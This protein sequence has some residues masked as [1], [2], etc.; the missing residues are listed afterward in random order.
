[1]RANFLKNG[2]ARRACRHENAMKHRSVLTIAAIVCLT[3]GF[4]VSCGRKEPP[5]LPSTPMPPGVADLSAV[6]KSGDVV[7]SWHVPPVN[8]VENRIDRFVIYRSATQAGDC[9]DCPVLFT[10]LSDVSV[11]GKSAG[12]AVGY[13]DDTV[14]KAISLRYKVIGF[15]KKDQEGADSNIVEIRP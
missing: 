7:L 13:V 9:T 2:V 1:V 8:A 5:R 3:A 4:L 12:D 14:P 15:T 6:M 10:A 11:A